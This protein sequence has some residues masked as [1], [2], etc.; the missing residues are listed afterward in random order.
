MMMM[1]KRLNND[2]LQNKETD[3]TYYH[4]V[5]S[6]VDSNHK[7]GCKLMQSNELIVVGF[8]CVTHFRDES[9]QDNDCTGT[10]EQKQKKK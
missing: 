4:E 1:M 5:R 8:L 9:F 3:E 2:P 7:F 10:D 6:A